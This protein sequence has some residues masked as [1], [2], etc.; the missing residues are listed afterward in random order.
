MRVIHNW[1]KSNRDFTVGSMLYQRFGKNE[2]LKLL[3]DKGHSSF[4]QKELAVELQKI[5]QNSIHKPLLLVDKEVIEMPGSEN[6][7]L[8]AIRKEWLPIYAKM[9]LL[10]HELDKYSDRN[11]WEAIAWRQPRAREIKELEKLCNG[12]W[13]KRDYFEKHGKLP[14]VHEATIEKPTDP[15]KL[16]NQINNT[17]RNIRRNRQEMNK[18]GADPKYAQFYADYKLKLRKLTDEEYNDQD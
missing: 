18:P 9:N 6:D 10:R 17:K 7:I 1:L 13:A 15:V 12:I 16:A 14:F 3:L 5:A 4:L 11:D 2:Q 8:E